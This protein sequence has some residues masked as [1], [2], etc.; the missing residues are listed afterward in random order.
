MNAKDELQ[1]FNDV[2]L[3]SKQKSLSLANSENS[4]ETQNSTPVQESNSIKENNE[5]HSSD[6]LLLHSQIK[7]TELKTRMPNIKVF[8]GNLALVLNIEIKALY[9]LNPI[10]PICNI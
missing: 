3:I 8:S 9:S 10:F 7:S 4:I 2:V 5:E 6:N 1:Q